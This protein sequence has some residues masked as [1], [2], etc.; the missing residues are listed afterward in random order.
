MKKLKKKPFLIILIIGIVT[1][2]LMFTFGRY[3][4]NNIWDYYLITKGFYFNSDYLASN[5]MSHVNDEWDGG[6]VHFNVRNNMSEIR[7]TNY[8]INYTAECVVKGA[9]AAYAEC[10]MNGEN[11]NT[12]TGSLSSFK[13]CENTTDDGID[14]S[15]F[16]KKECHSGGYIWINQIATKE[17]YFDVVLTDSNYEITDVVV[18]VSVTSNSPYK[19]TLSGDFILSKNAITEDNVT[20]KYKNFQD[21]DR[22]NISNS[23]TETKCVKINW[24]SDNFLID[25]D[26]SELISY[27]IDGDDYINEIVFSIG[28]KD[29][30]SYIFYKRDF[31][32]TFDV[33]EFTLEK[34]ECE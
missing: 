16:N 17:L 11:T 3:I 8:D 31:G 34:V 21:Y 5:T 27:D 12:Q 33:S 15:E 28:A 30:K 29:S 9:A 1:C 19:K 4:Y 20:M 10:R 32:A 26:P 6:S 22:L 13:I 18:N 2:V 7:I 24:D 25:T 14:V 23:Y